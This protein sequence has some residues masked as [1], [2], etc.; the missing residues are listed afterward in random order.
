M[1]WITYFILAYVILG[2]QIGAG[3]FLRFQGASPNLV[4]LAVIFITMNA[5]RDAALLGAFSLGVMQDL[6]TAQ[7]PGLFASLTGWSQCSSSAPTTSF[8]ESTR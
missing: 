1:R 7:P 3:P 2:L 6:L 5:P 4:L 8:T